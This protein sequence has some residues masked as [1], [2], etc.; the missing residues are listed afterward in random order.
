MVNFTFAVLLLLSSSVFVLADVSICTQNSSKLTS[1]PWTAR[2]NAVL[3]TNLADGSLS[4]ACGNLIDNNVN[5]DDMFVVIPNDM[6]YSG[7]GCGLC[8]EISGSSS[9]VSGIYKTVDRFIADLANNPYLVMTDSQIRRLS[10]VNSSAN[11]AVDFHTVPCEDM[12]SLK[13]GFTAGSNDY[14]SKLVIF[15]HSVPVEKVLIERDGLYYET[16]RD[17]NGGI[18]NLPQGQQHL[19]FQVQVVAVT[20]EV[21]EFQVDSFGS[22][23]STVGKQFKAVCTETASKNAASLSSPSFGIFAVS[24][25]FGLYASMSLW[26]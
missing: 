22:M 13:W 4:S 24:M 15:D 20:G 16:A 17:Q 9:G 10:G 8:L 1:T 5:G 7:M 14:S 23:N 3:D 18:F 2:A 26:M 25:L 6:F 12:V 21:L 11:L 19:P